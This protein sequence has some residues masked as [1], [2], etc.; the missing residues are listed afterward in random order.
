MMVTKGWYNPLL[1]WSFAV[2]TDLFLFLN[3]FLH[4]FRLLVRLLLHP[5]HLLQ[6]HRLQGQEL[7]L[8]HRNINLMVH[9]K[10]PAS[11]PFHFQFP[12]V[13]HGNLK[14]LGGNNTRGGSS[15]GSVR[16]KVSRGGLRPQRVLI[17]KMYLG[18]GGFRGSGGFQHPTSSGRKKFSPQWIN[19]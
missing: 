18:K 9:Q 11:P 6:G 17:P 4:F 5:F 13:I 2:I 10:N 19:F 3:L 12:W 14:T 15:P 8:E 16:F 7:W 1:S